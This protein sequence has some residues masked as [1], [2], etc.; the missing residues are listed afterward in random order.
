[1][2]ETTGANTLVL[3]L[4][5]LSRR[6]CFIGQALLNRRF[7]TFDAPLQSRVSAHER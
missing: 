6:L 3:N 7:L 4:A 2:M 1:M 5:F